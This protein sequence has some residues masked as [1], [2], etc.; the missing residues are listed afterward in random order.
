MPTVIQMEA[1]ECGAA[2]LAMVMGFYGRFVPLDVLRVECGVSRDGSNAAN[3]LRAARRYGMEAKGLSIEAKQVGTVHL[4]AIIFWAF[5]HFMV[6]ERVTERR[7][8]RKRLR[9]HVNDPMVGP[10]VIGW[11]DF[12]QDF[13]GIILVME[14]GDDFETEGR[15]VRFRDGLAARAKGAAPGLVIAFVVSLLLVVPGLAAPAFQRAF[16]DRVLGAGDRGFVLPLVG[17]IAIAALL[18]FVLTGIQQSNLL[19]VEAKAA[20]NSSARFFAHVLRLPTDFINQRQPAEV[21]SRLRSNDVVAQIL[22]RDLTTAVLNLVIVVFYAVLMIRYSVVLSI[23]G[24]GMALLNAA[25]LRWVSRTRKDSAER[26]RADKGNLIATSFNA[27]RMI[28]TIKATG[29]EN[30]AFAR[31]G[32]FQAKLLNS[33]QQLGR[34]TALLTVVPPVLAILNSGVVLLIG[35]LQAIEG[36]ITVSLLVAFQLLLN[37]LTRPVTQLTNLGSQIQET[38]T[39]VARLLDVEKYPQAPV[40]TMT[41]EAESAPLSL[42]GRLELRDV[43]FGYSHLKPPLLTDFDLTLQPG[44]RVA[45]VGPSGSGKST[46]GK[47]IVGLH[48]HW[49]GELLYDG[50]A[51]ERIPR[52]LFASA[53]TYVD[54]EPMLFEGTVR[55]NV[56]LW[57]ESF[58]DEWVV[59]AL[60]DADIFDVI[61]DRPGSVNSPVHEGGRNF[62]GG[63]KQRLEIARALVTQP[64]LLVLDEAMSALDTATEQRID[65]NIRRRGCACVIIAHRLSTVRDADEIIVLDTGRIVQ[66]GR[67]DDLID[68]PGLYRDLIAASESSLG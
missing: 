51:R 57:D 3:L 13:P 2:S 21:G 44:R 1:V 56:T 64:S 19:R 17:A 55:E 16:I 66:R 62:S 47:V 61:A 46:I 29:G 14:P 60:Q 53:V 4:P 45:I 10:R 7:W 12:D 39:D 43:S 63:Q 58:P 68:T 31:W 65:D 20:L 41:P 26:L 59:S 49:T 34:P 9:F 22:A 52:D 11:K 37:N 30:D 18:T 24:I 28:E 38:T 32:G 42:G 15:P 54:Q 36:A 6:L 25:V 40:F 67:H 50:F 23:V 48:E 27:V 5:S 33:Q 35:G 8:G